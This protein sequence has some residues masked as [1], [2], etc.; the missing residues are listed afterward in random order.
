MASPS[1]AIGASQ[2]SLEVYLKSFTM[3]QNKIF[4]MCCVACFSNTLSR[5]ANHFFWAFAIALSHYACD[6]PNQ[7]DFRPDLYY[8]SNPEFAHLQ[9]SLSSHSEV[10]YCAGALVASYSRFD[11]SGSVQH[12]PYGHKELLKG[13]FFTRHS[14]YTTS[15]RIPGL[16]MLH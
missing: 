5:S 10:C 9:T 2:W 13:P 11:F 3:L 16:V 6:L 15:A 7:Q 14:V 12:T 4:A 1:V 8:L